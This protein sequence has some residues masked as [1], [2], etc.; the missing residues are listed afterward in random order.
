[1]NL[2]IV[3]QCSFELYKIGQKC[4]NLRSKYHMW[5][6]RRCKYSIVYFKSGMSE[7][8]LE[9]PFRLLGRS[10]FTFIYSFPPF[11]P[12]FA[13]VFKVYVLEIL[14]GRHKK[15]NKRM[16]FQY[17]ANSAAWGISRLL[18]SNTFSKRHHIFSKS[19]NIFSKKSQ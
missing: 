19:Y 2:N 13:F 18:I 7:I 9:K 15:I 8:L 5:A 1:M 10:T 17:F 11:S 12:L 3:C 16:L 14:G 6:F 4:S